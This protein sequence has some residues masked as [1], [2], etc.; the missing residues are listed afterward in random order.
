MRYWLMDF[1]GI[2]LFAVALV[3]LLHMG[4]PIEQAIIEWKEGL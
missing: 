2:A 3:V 4:S 1:I